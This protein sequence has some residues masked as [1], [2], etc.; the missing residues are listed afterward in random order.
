MMRVIGKS[1]PIVTIWNWLNQKVNKNAHAVVTIGQKMAERIAKQTPYGPSVPK[2]IPP[3]ADTIRIRP[4]SLEENP[5]KNELNPEVIHLIL[6][7]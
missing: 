6:Y 5:L 4:I 3:W 7:S 2:V 1:N